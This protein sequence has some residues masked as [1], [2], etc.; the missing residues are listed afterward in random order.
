M[1]GLTGRTIVGDRPGPQGGEVSE[2]QEHNNTLHRLQRTGP[3]PRID[4]RPRTNHEGS[5]QDVDT[6]S[7]PTSNPTILAGRRNR[8]VRQIHTREMPRR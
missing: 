8:A 6:A 4:S 5:A 7:V 1:K 3:E 2:R